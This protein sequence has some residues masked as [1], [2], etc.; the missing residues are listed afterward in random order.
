MQRKRDSSQAFPPDMLSSS[1]A[2]DFANARHLG[3]HHRPATQ[4]RRH[5]YITPG[6]SPAQKTPT[7]QE[8]MRRGIS[9]QSAINNT[10]HAIQP[11]HTQTGGFSDDVSS[12][13]EEEMRVEPYRYNDPSHRG[14][15]QTS[16]PSDRLGGSLAFIHTM[17]S[18]G[19]TRVVLRGR[20]AKQPWSQ[21]ARPALRFRTSPE[22]G[23]PSMVERRGPN[24][25]V[26]DEQPGG[27]LTSGTLVHQVSPLVVPNVTSSTQVVPTNLI[28]DLTGLITRCSPDP[29]CGGTYGNIYKCIYHG[30]DGDVVVAV[31]AIRSQFISD[32]VF[33]RELG[34][35]RRLRHSN[36]LKFM[37]TTSDFGPSVALVAPWVANGTLTSF[38]KQN[39][40]ILTLLDRMCLVRTS[41]TFPARTDLS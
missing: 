12:A 36:I 9:S 41:S 30:P 22:F 23:T 34:I 25:V 17:P 31:K 1:G 27:A 38:L 5:L 28:P 3:D 14:I 7:F 40:D 13:E 18:A 20:A 2:T 33:R 21:S 8:I 15:Q 4:R 16:N 26:L 10:E 29:V 37:G 32:Q 6:R 24:P 39:S 35:W 11:I 19:Q